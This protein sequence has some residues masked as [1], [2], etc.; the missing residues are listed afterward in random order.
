M[1]RYNPRF[2]VLAILATIAMF[3]I[4][5]IVMNALANN[6][7]EPPKRVPEITQQAAFVAPVEMGD[8]SL[9]VTV[10]GEATPRRQVSLSPQ[11]SGRVTYV[12]NNLVNGGF[13]KRGQLL[14]QIEDADYELAVVRAESTVA[15]AEQ[16]L[17]RA[18]AEADVARREIEDL[19]ITNASAL[20][21]K[22]PQLAEAR[23]SLKAAEAQLQDAELQLRRT[24]IYAPFDGLVESETVDVGQF[25]GAGVMFATIFATDVIEVELQLTSDQMGDLGVPIAFNA[26]KDNPGPIVALHANVGGR[27]CTWEGRITRTG[28]TINSNTRMISVYAEVEDPFGK[29]SDN[30]TPLAPGLYVNA[31]I[32]GRGVDGVLIAPRAALRGRGQFYVAQTMDADEW[33]AERAD[34]NSPAADADAEG[35]RSGNDA[36]TEENPEQTLTGPVDV[37]RIRDVEVL[38]S[39]AD[40]VYVTSGVSAGERVVISPVSGCL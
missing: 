8:V 29:G 39:D 24:R 5:F 16:S 2:I 17:V 28:A 15:S 35:D 4:G 11:V 36:Q 26:D 10:Q 13:V 7:K 27:L 33:R 30:G 23:A 18:E 1:T 9:S 6:K 34:V 40:H 37:L 31:D 3:I 14:A 25:V 38:R 20:A 19:G 32:S 21:L 22:E 12:A